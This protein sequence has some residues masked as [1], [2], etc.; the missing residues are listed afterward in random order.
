MPPAGNFV[1]W[2]NLKNSLAHAP[3][4]CELVVNM[5]TKHKTVQPLKNMDRIQGG[6]SFGL[7]VYLSQKKKT[8]LTLT[9]I[10]MQTDAH[11]AG[12]KAS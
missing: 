10:D 5:K 1:F 2:R 7:V 4:G 6:K 8:T 9:G 12:S 3:G 11:E